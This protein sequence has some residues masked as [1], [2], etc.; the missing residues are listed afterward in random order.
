MIDRAIQQSTRP[1]RRRG[2]RRDVRPGVL[3]PRD[4]YDQCLAAAEKDGIPFSLWL[5]LG[6]A[7][8]AGVEPD[9]FDLA[10]LEAYQRKNFA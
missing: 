5:R 1:R 10:D 7:K 8:A 3:W 6:A 4:L 9:P 2:V